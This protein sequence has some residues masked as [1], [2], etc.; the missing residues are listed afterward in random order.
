MK[1]IILCFMMITSLSSLAAV[2]LDKLTGAWK[3]FCTQSQ[4]GGKQ[5]YMIETYTFTKTGSFQLDRQW[6]KDVKCTIKT[7]AESDSGSIVVGNENTNGGFNPAGTYETQYKTEKGIELGLLWVD[8]KYTK[9]RLARGFGQSQNTM[10]GVF[11]YTK[12]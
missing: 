6:F 12:Q 9:L 7:Q 3:L 11:E 1:K 8:S 4:S 5:G 10:L 2:D